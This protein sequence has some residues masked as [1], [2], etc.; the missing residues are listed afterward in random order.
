[1]RFSF[2]AAFDSG[3]DPPTPKKFVRHGREVGEGFGFGFGFG[4]GDARQA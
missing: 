4:Y 2:Q 1:M 3:V